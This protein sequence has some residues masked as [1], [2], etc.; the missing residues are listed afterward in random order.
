[1]STE[2][3]LLS[4]WG[5]TVPTRSEVHVPHD[6]DAVDAMLKEADGRGAIARGLGRGYGDVAQNAG[7]RVLDMTAL[8][9]VRNLDV[10][11]GTITVDAG[12]ALGDLLHLIVPLGWFVAV[13]PGTRHVTVG[14]AV[15]SDIHGKNHH[16]DGSFCDHVLSLELHTPG[17]EHVRLTPGETPDEFWATAGGI[18]LTGVVTEVT[19]QLLRIETDRIRVDTQRASDLDE[20]MTLMEEGDE[21]YRYSVAWLDCLARG[22]SMGRA[23][24]S[25]GDHATL[26]DLPV[27]ER[28]PVLRF[29]PHAR[30]AA[31]PWAPPGL[32]NRL[33][34]RAFNEL[35]F[36]K[37][38]RREIGGIESL[39]WFFHPLDSVNGWNRLYGRRGFVQYQFVV[40]FGQEDTV[41][42][43]V[44]RLSDARTPSFLAVLKRF[45]PG[46]G[47]L[48]FP[49]SGWT[50]ALDIPAD[51]PGLARLLDGLDDLVVEAGGR[52][53]LAKDSRLRPELLSVMYPELDRWR[54]IRS[55]LDPEAVMCSDLARRLRL[56]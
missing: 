36:R 47:L 27:A 28:D 49:M 38:P 18:G 12:L 43:S 4:G 46:H 20:L 52:V 44:R 45:G 3:R 16:R 41:R 9:Q 10:G 2:I 15:A 51:L 40:P 21:R 30:L 54:E 19:L 11:A 24:L 1:M 53:Y 42:E 55:R 29:D 8:E 26:D 25:R 14:G 5:R 7:G 34:V 56:V 6:R 48:S 23:V 13:T 50:L 17:G 35:W 39:P 33:T 37:A 22:A 31:P 32:L